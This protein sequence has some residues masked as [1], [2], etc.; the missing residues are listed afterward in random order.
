MS[1]LIY[2][3]P[4]PFP[5]EAPSSWLSR[6]ALAQGCRVSE[7]KAFLGF[8]SRRTGRDVVDHTSALAAIRQRCNLPEQAFEEVARVMNAVPA[9][10]FT[11]SGWPRF[12]YCPLCLFERPTAWLDI[13]WRFAERQYCL[14]HGCHLEDRCRECRGAI[15]GPSERINSHAARE[16]HASLRR[17]QQCCFDLAS[18]SPRYPYVDPRSMRVKPFASVELRLIAGR[19]IVPLHS[20]LA[21]SDLATRMGYSRHQLQSYPWWTP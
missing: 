9:R 18:V 1:V 15:V 21:H 7:A 16:G 20:S 2:G 4:H 6:L 14:V 3:V 11:A 5:F 10:L 8:P 17:C 12:H 19:G 13:H